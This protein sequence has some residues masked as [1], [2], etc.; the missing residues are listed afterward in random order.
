MTAESSPPDRYAP[1]GT[2]ERSSRK[3]AA[4]ISVARSS[5]AKSSIVRDVSISE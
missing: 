4:S 1:T 2:S 5:S 3:R